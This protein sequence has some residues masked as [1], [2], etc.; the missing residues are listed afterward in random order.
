MGLC[1]L[2]ENELTNRYPRELYLCA[3]SSCHDGWSD[4]DNNDE[5]PMG[6]QDAIHGMYCLPTSLSSSHLSMLVAFKMGHLRAQPR[7]KNTHWRT[8]GRS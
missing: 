1:Q 4:G 3:Y 5:S 6:G 2:K 7:D 8:R